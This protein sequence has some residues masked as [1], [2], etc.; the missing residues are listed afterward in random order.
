MKKIDLGQTMQT[1]A[2]IGVLLGI[3]LLVY[4]LSQ[5]RELAQAQFNFDRDTAFQSSE[6]AMLGAD[7]ST[8]WE[9]SIFEPASLSPAQIR[10]LD[11]FYAI[12]VSRM[13]N[14]WDLEQAGM[15]PRGSTRAEIEYNVPFY[16]GNEFSHL[17]WSYQRDY[18]AA[19]FV[20]LMDEVLASIDQRENQEWIE[21]FAEKLAGMVEQ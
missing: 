4:E 8:A 11:S 17:W 3:L 2:N 18:W 6:I 5:T 14:A 16:F 10:V 7:L 9:Q 19:D 15:L 20:A 21:S 1:I 13:E 12:Q